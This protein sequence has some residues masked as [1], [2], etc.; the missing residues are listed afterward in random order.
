MKIIIGAG[1]TGGHVFPAQAVAREIQ[2]RGGRV[3]LLTDSRG[4]RFTDSFPADETL[5]LPA[6]NIRAGSI[7]KRLSSA[8]GLGKGV[9]QAVMKVNR[10]KPDA[11][12]GFGGYPSFPAGVAAFLTRTPLYLHEQ[13][14]IVGRTNR[15]LVRFAEKLLLSFPDTQNIPDGREFFLT[16]NPVR[17]NILEHIDTPYAL[18]E[19]FRILVTGG[20]Q[21]A[22]VFA[23]V[24]PQACAL[25]PSDVK[26]KLHIV[27]QARAEDEDALKS[28]Y[29][30]AG[31]T[32]DVRGFIRNMGEEL[33]K[34]TL[35]FTRSGASS[36]AE[37]TA[38]GRPA[39]LVPLPTA[40]D[41]QQTLNAKALQD[42]GAAVLT[43]QPAF[44]PEK[45]AERLTDFVRFPEKLAAIAEASKKLGQPEAGVKIVKEILKSVPLN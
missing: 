32:A 27:H 31:V 42:K 6:G 18:G 11:V 44:T 39:I 17:E 37:L 7:L 30:Q 36:L 28:A 24:L 10:E 15:F 34:A 41:D 3:I 26:E 14:V 19:R 2:S 45:V 40:A 16:G 9:L 22:A 43:P 5:I 1:G 8:F 38:L 13:N 33:T 35:C 20:S 12:I 23:T 25:T 21:G 4:A 29:E